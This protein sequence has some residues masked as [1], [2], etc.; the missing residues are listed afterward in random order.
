MTVQLTSRGTSLMNSPVAACF[1]IEGLSR[2][3]FVTG[4]L[5]KLK[6]MNAPAPSADRQ[7]WSNTELHLRDYLIALDGDHNG[8][9]YRQIA[10]VIYGR[11]RVRSTWNAENRSLKDRVR[12]AVERGHDFMRGGY[13]DLLRRP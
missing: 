13:R 10:Q 1:E 5:A 6:H 2:L 7:T 4:A 9:T 3:P 12:R 11:D 8:A